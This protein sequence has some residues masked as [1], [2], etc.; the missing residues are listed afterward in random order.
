MLKLRNAK[1]DDVTF[2]T[3]L[4]KV[5]MKEHIE[6]A[7]IEYFKEKQLERV[8]YG[9]KY[10][11]I[12]EYDNKDIGL[13]KINKESSP[14]D[15]IQIQILPEYQNRGIGS[16]ILKTVIK[17]AKSLSK[18]IRLSVYKNNPALKLYKRNGFRVVEESK[19]SFIMVRFFHE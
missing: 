3:L 18:S 4:R 12:V 5:S 14:W 2:L 15:V 8:L 11:Q 10:A 19:D 17:E 7:G 16:L 13:F 6:K 1:K 9:F